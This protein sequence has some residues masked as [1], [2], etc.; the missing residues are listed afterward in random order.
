[1]DLLAPFRPA[2]TVDEVLDRLDG[3]ISAARRERSR[4]G[5]FAS[6]YR[7]VTA[8]VREAILRGDFEDGG[9]MAVLDVAFANRYLEAL[10]RFSAGEPT[11]KCWEEAFGATRRWR[12]IVLQHLLLGINAHINLDLGAATAAVSSGGALAGLRRDFDAVN[13][14]LC[15]ML[16]D[17]QDR[18]TRIWPLMGLLDRVGCRTDEAVLHFSILHARDA[19]WDVA[20]TLVH[21]DPEH[22]DREL[23]RVDEWATVLARLVQT[24][25]MSGSAAALMIRVT[26]LRGIP[27]VLDA[28]S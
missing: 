15:A 10:H 28:L 12:P 11:S 7:N 20:T 3:V 27:K 22:V 17:V 18:L 24:P 26:E 16:D 5:Y 9:R 25:G 13:G 2:E 19:A 21:L 1:M 23:A 4:V 6:L 8:R 14:I